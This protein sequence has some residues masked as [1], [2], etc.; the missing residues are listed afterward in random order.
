[1][2]FQ[3][4]PRFIIDSSR[5]S[6]YAAP[7]GKPT[8]LCYQ[9][10]LKGC[11][12]RGGVDQCVARWVCTYRIS[13]FATG[14][15]VSMNSPSNGSQP[16]DSLYAVPRN[17]ARVRPESVRRTRGQERKE[18]R[19]ETPT[20]CALHLSC[21][22]LATT[23]LYG[24]RA[25]WTVPSCLRGWAGRHLWARKEMPDSQETRMVACLL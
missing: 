12:L 8:K 9:Q 16:T 3:C 15:R 20:A 6:L 17:L 10:C 11:M 25:G 14:K 18:P 5:Y 24:L 19:R 2:L 23:G 13:L 21:L 1:M 7:P 22:P 4:V